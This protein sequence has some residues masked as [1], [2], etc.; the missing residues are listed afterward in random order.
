[1]KDKYNKILDSFKHY[2]SYLYDQTVD[3]WP[4]GRYSITVK[5]DDGILMEYD[6]FS[7]SIRRIQP[8]NYTKDA[9]SLRKDIGNNLKKIIQTRG[10]AQSD[11]AE[12]CG[13]TQAMLSRYIH[14][15]SMPSVYIV[16]A[17]ASA[18]DCRTIDIIGE[19]YEE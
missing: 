17:L 13:I 5:L 11:I 7:E 16:N 15:T 1:M 14:G 9:E 19:C 12:N 6:S 4:S 8:K 10:I 2:Y 18:L 3:W